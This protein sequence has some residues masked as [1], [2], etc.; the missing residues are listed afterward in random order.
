[1]K[2]FV[3]LEGLKF[4]LELFKKAMASDSLEK[5]NPLKNK[6]TKESNT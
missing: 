4:F 6:E 2:E 3:D 1:M 5:E